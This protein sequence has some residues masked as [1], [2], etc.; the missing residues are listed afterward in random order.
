MKKLDGVIFDMDGVIFD[1]EKY[2]LKIWTEVFK[3]RGYD[4]KPEIYISVMGTGRA[5]VIKTFKNNFGADLPMDEM[6][7]EK[8][9]M[10]LDAVRR[11]LVPIKEGAES[12]LKYLKA[13]NISTAL[14]TSSRRERLDLQIEMYD[15]FNLFDAIVSGE[16]IVNGKPA[17][18]IFI[19]AADKINASYEDCIVIEDSF[20]GIKGA[21]L[22]GMHPIHVED[23]RKADKD[24]LKYAEE[25]F[26]NLNEIKE[27]IAENYII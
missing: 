20:A 21:R 23:L 22:A 8:D 10:L 12:M 3:K 14:A 7:K 2:Y 19:K 11:N 5:N 6:Y 24:I 15:I 26:L 1:T 27:Y 17:P 4:L 16:D 25:N 18:D 9:E 13:N